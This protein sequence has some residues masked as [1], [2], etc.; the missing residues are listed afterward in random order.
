MRL[1]AA[2]I[3]EEVVAALAEFKIG[4][5]E[6]VT[7]L[8]RRHAVVML[9]P[10]YTSMCHASCAGA[11]RSHDRAL[12]LV[13][14]YLLCMEDANSCGRLHHSFVLEKTLRLDRT[15]EKKLDSSHSIRTKKKQKQSSS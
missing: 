14:A 4:S 2:W 15:W 13:Q 5:L 3:S 9:G 7:R 8:V 11:L 6:E 10:K 12:R 1:A